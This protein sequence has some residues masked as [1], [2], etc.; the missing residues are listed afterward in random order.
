MYCTYPC[1]PFPAYVDDGQLGTLAGREP[2]TRHWHHSRMFFS[3]SARTN[4]SASS[5]GKNS[6]P[7]AHGVGYDRIAMSE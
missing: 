4:T 1:Q 2:L 7:P 3:P 5:N 6:L